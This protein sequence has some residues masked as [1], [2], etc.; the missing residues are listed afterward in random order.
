MLLSLIANW[1][2][3]LAGAAVLAVVGYVLHCEA[4]KEDWKEAQAIA[5]RQAAENAK[6]ALR[7]LKNK[8]RTDENYQRNIARLAADVKRLRNAR[9]SFVPSAGGSPGSAELAC[10]DRAALDDALQRYRA[11]IIGLLEEGAKAV[12]GLN[13]A[14]AWA[15]D[16]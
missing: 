11:G 13:E 15:A 7:D 10:F 6:Q 5:Q 2:Q 8:E 14:R 1:R 12:E 3:I 16:R 4:V 9:P